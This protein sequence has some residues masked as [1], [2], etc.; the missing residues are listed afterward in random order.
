MRVLYF[1]RDYTTHDRRFLLKLAESPHEIW[2]L[3]LE[4]D[5]IVYEDRPLPESVRAAEWEGGDRPAG[6]PG[7]WLRLMPSFQSVLD[8]VRPDLVHAGPVPSCGFMTAVAGFHPFLLMSWGSD[9]LVD[10]DRDDLFRWMTR[11]ALAHSDM[12]ACDSDVVRNKAQSLVHYPDERVV[13]FPWGIDLGLFCPG[14][15][16]LRVR[17]DLGCEEAF[18]ILS[19]RSWEPIYGINVLLEAFRQAATR[20]EALRLILLGDG[21]LA[22]QIDR[23]V[24]EHDL[25]GCVHRPGRVP[26]GQL[27]NYFRAADLYLSCAHS[28]GTSISLLEAMATG[29]PVV[30]TDIPGNREWVKAGENGWLAREGDAAAF[31]RAIDTAAGSPPDT[32]RR[33]RRSN[34][35]RAQ[36]RANWD[37]NAAKVLEAYDRLGSCQPS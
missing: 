27:P 24:G 36:A 9:I 25:A 23:F 8:R 20:H 18:V 28:D 6:T 29:L 10:A 7:D 17:R 34:I 2:F 31:A 32:L 15:D 19:T 3:R 16:S 21:S 35:V 14:Q 33:I 1:S 26:H 4:D 37:R 22:P 5:G 30:V 11:Y 13:Q 12:L